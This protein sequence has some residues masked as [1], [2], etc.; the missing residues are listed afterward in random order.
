MFSLQPNPDYVPGG[1]NNFWLSGSSAR[2]GPSDRGVKSSQYEQDAEGRYGSGVGAGMRSHHEK[3]RP[4]TQI[5]REYFTHL[6][7]IV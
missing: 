7:N 3:D 1:I 2:E 6:R 5:W 4:Q